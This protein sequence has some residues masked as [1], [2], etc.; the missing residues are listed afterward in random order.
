MKRIYTVASALAVL[1]VL[2]STTAYSYVP[3]SPSRTWEKTPWY[4]VDMRGLSSV[5]DGDGGVTR[6][7]N[8]LNSLDAWDGAGA[9]RVTFAT[10]GTLASGFNLTDRIPMVNFTDPNDNCPAGYLACTFN[11][12]E[13]RTDGTWRILDADIV[14]NSTNYD[15]TSEGEHPGGAGCSGEY[16]IE[17]IMVHEMGHG[18]GLDHT[19]VTGATMVPSV[20]ACDNNLM[21]TEA[22]DENGLLAL[23]GSAP[24]TSCERYHGSLTGTGDNEYEPSDIRGTDGY[25]YYGYPATHTGRLIGPAGTDFDLYLEYQNGTTWT[26]VASSTSTSSNETVSY[27]G[28]AGNYRWRVTSFS[29]SGVY[30]FYWDR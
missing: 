2:A 6:V 27:S 19:S 17:G 4:I 10:P 18:L 24:C 3:L 8:A 5:N 16:Y 21:T 11:Y 22:D 29:G 13:Q 20:P 12:A 25:Y 9:G 7:V 14:T 1:L 28:P 23:Y 30:R 15:F 26:T